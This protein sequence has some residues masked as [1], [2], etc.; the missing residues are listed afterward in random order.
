MRVQ[1]SWPARVRSPSYPETAASPGTFQ[2][3]TRIAVP[4][5]SPAAARAWTDIRASPSTGRG[6]GALQRPERGGAGG[7]G[8][9]GPKQSSGA[10]SPARNGTGSRGRRSS[11]HIATA[12][13]SRW[14]SAV[15]TCPSCQRAAP[16]AFLRRGPPRAPLGRAEPVDGR[17]EPV[18]VE[19][20]RE[21]RGGREP[22]ER[23]T[24]RVEGRRQHHRRDRGEARVA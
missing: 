24:V 6:D 4:R 15:I 23:T 2:G 19:R 10:P 18:E 8:G 1:T 21:R 11:V 13:T 3:G 16:A 12:S 20:L 9:S 22:V 7:S 14:R 5:R 17:D